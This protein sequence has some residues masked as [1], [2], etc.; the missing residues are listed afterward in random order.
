MEGEGERG[1]VG[2]GGGGEEGQLAY[3]NGPPRYHYSPLKRSLIMLCDISSTITTD[4]LQLRCSHFISFV[5]FRSFQDNM[6]AF[7][8]VGEQINSA[9]L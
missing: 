1:G 7:S 5:E 6:K 2:G 9:W 8:D 3:C 4:V